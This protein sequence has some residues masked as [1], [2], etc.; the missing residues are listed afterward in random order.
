M[1]MCEHKPLSPSQ[2]SVEGYRSS[3]PTFEQK[4]GPPFSISQL[5]TKRVPIFDWFSSC[6]SQ[7]P[8]PS[9]SWEAFQASRSWLHLGCSGI[10][11]AGDSFSMDPSKPSA[12][13]SSVH[14]PP[15]EI[16]DPLQKPSANPAAS[17]STQFSSQRSEATITWKTAACSSGNQLQCHTWNQMSL[18]GGPFRTRK[19][20]AGELWKTHCGYPPN[21]QHAA[22]TLRTRRGYLLDMV[23]VSF[24]HVQVPTKHA[25]DS[26]LV[27]SRYLP[28][29]IPDMETRR[30]EW[31]Q[32]SVP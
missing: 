7:E 13:R 20:P 18:P 27:R 9:S 31:H 25:A 30:K 16:E 10:L 28:E 6:C 12:P 22:D 32:I 17:A 26:S 4:K 24:R 5:S 15:S 29:T 14:I 2:R 23:Q 3:T 11:S 8:T 19:N 1:H 21:T